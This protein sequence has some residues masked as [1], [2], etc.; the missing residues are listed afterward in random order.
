QSTASGIHGLVSC[1]EWTGVPLAILLEEAGMRKEAKWIIAEGADA[2][3]MSRSVPIEK[4]LDDAVV[5]LY[6]NG[7]RL[8]PSNGYPMRLLLPGWE[9]NAN[10]KWLRRIQVSSSPAMTK[11]ETSKYTDLLPDG[12]ASMFSFPMGVKS[13]ITSPSGKY[14]MQG[15]GLYQISGLAWSGAGKIRRVEVSADGGQSWG[16]AALSEP[17]LSKALVRFR[18]PWRWN[19][20]PAVLQ[21]RAIDET[22]AIQPKREAL[23]GKRGTNYRY[24]YHAIQSWN[25]GSNGEVAN[26]YA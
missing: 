18:M 20:G 7:E 4:A 26:V 24:H 10:V 3:A 22:G 17:V 19:G 23:L 16:K 14:T 12:R 11:D 9:G 25:V 13:V 15:P 6:Q 5:A 21:S 8:R 1:S 2:A